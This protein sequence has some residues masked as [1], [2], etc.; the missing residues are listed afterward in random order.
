MFLR[1]S[2]NLTLFTTY[3][4]TNLFYHRETDTALPKDYLL[5][6]ISANSILYA[7][8]E[9]INIFD[10]AYYNNTILSHKAN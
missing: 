6:T 4:S 9:I 8:S 1:E 3:S 7:R 10:Q 5:D 2:D